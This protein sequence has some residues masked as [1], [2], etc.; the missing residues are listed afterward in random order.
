M[1]GTVRLL[2]LFRNKHYIDTFLIIAACVCVSW[3]VKEKENRRRD[4]IVGNFK[5]NIRER[6]HGRGQTD[7]MSR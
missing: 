4:I 5:S 7:L 3:F 6:V 2:T 1:T